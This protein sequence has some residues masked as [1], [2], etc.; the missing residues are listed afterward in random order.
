[1]V[2]DRLDRL[3]FYST[4]RL[5]ARE[6]FIAFSSFKLCY[7]LFLVAPT[8]LSLWKSRAV[9]VLQWE[10]WSHCSQNPE[11]TRHWSRYPCR[12]FPDWR[13]QGTRGAGEAE[14]RAQVVLAP[15]QMIDVPVEKGSWLPRLLQSVQDSW[16]AIARETLNLNCVSGFL[17]RSYSIS[18][19]SHGNN[20]VK[21]IKLLNVM[22]TSVVRNAERTC[23]YKRYTVL[24]CKYNI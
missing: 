13:A 18:V 15:L 20:N 7:L 8:Q 10:R 17:L 1:M 14:P 11:M 22:F 21:L 12:L 2:A 23:R 4:K 5:T 19:L 16:S 6:D 9:A 3:G 24:K